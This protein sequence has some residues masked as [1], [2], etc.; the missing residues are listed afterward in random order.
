MNLGSP[1]R[2]SHLFFLPPRQT[3]C[4]SHS[5]SR[6]QRLSRLKSLRLLRSF[7][8]KNLGVAELHPP[9]F[10]QFVSKPFLKPSLVDMHH[11]CGWET[12]EIR[13]GRVAVGADLFAVK[14]VAQ[15]QVARQFL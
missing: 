4:L 6:V 10:V 12:V 9:K 8:A 5:V 14:Q 2:Q 13:R 3:G 7:A 1:R 11:G 15:L